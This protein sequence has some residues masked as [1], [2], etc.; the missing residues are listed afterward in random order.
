M[1]IGVTQYASF[2][3]IGINIRRAVKYS[4]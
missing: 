1:S 2:T 3:V 4:G